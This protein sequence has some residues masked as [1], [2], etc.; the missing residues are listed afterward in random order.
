M[1][2]PHGSR[3]WMSALPQDPRGRESH[4]C[5]S[6]HTEGPPQ[7]A[8][9]LSRFATRSAAM[10]WARAM[11]VALSS[12]ACNT[13]IASLPQ[14]SARRSAIACAAAPCMNGSSTAWRRSRTG[15]SLAA[16]KRASSFPIPWLEVV[17]PDPVELTL[18]MVFPSTLVTD[19][20]T[21]S[22]EGARLRKSSAETL[23]CKAVAGSAIRI[24]AM[25]SRHA[26]RSTAARVLSRTF[27]SI[28]SSV[29]RIASNS[30]SPPSP[31]VLARVP[32]SAEPGVLARR[33][34][35]GV[36]VLRREACSDPGR[37]LLPRLLA[38]RLRL[39]DRDSETRTAAPHSCSMTWRRLSS[40][41]SA[42][43]SVFGLSE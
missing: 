4:P 14:L 28:S 20:A 10:L 17:V 43:L 19:A 37:D 31:G 40:A 6:T 27:R 9:C 8:L 35:A 39:P 24:C 41:E 22:P 32:E 16:C 12:I 1:A 26:T 18:V 30:C 7:R 29:C 25:L 15:A 21:D 23:L 38:A 2:T 11:S 3:N 5:T 13:S 34:E 42:A 36:P 33:P